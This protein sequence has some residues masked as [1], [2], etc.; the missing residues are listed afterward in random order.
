ME[1]VLYE[2]TT[3]GHWERTDT[4]TVLAVDVKPVS[5]PHS[6]TL[7]V[8][9]VFYHG[10]SERRQT[11]RKGRGLSGQQKMSPCGSNVHRGLSMRVA[12]AP[13]M[14]R[15]AVPPF[16]SSSVWPGGPRMWSR[17]MLPKC[18]WAPSQKSIAN[19]D[20]KSSVLGASVGRDSASRT[21]RDEGNVQG[22][23]VID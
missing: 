1:P 20:L 19:K 11:N 16:P 14:A 21:E 15:L 12:S 22:S 5:F 2:K 7:P 4:G 9:G 6:A 23:I 3:P 18:R 10:Y 17:D 8:G 13:W